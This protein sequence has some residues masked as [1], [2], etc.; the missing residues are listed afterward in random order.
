M[1]QSAG[2]EGVIDGFIIDG[3]CRSLQQQQST[4]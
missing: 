2:M 1:L 4:M 3:L